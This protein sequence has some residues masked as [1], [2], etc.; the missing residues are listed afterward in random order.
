MEYLSTTAIVTAIAS[1]KEEVSRFVQSTKDAIDC[2]TAPERLQFYAQLKMAEKAI[3]ELVSDDDIDSWLLDSAS[4]YD[5]S[6][7]QNLFGCKFE[8]REVGT[9]YDYSQTDDTVLFEMEKKAAELDKQ[10]K[11]RQKMLQNLNGEMYNAE[12]VQLRKPIK[13]SKTKVVVTIK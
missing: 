1:N 8:Q 4:Q 7:L 5:K 3:K 6:D 13:S 10:I 11:E 9:K 2:M 12:G